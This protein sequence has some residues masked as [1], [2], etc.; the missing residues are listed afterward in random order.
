VPSPAGNGRAVAFDPA[1][2]KIFYTLTNSTD[3]YVTD[4]ANAAATRVSVGI[5]FGALSWDAKRKV[6]WGGAYQSGLLGN[7]YQVTPQ[8]AATLQF[9][10]LPSGGNCYGQTPGFI[11]GLAY[12]EGP[13]LLDSD[14]SL[15]ISDDAALMVHHVDLHGNLLKS[16]RVPNDPRSGRQGCNTGIAVDGE[17]LWL[18]LQSGPDQPPHDIVRVAKSDPTKVVTSFAFSDVG[19][20]GPE[21]LALDFL[22]FG[23]RTLWSNEFSFASAL[24]LWEIGPSL[25][26]PLKDL[27]PEAATINS[28]FDHSMANEEGSLQ[29]YKCD[30]VVVTY[31][32]ELGNKDGSGSLPKSDPNYFQIQCRQGYAQDTL[33]T[34]FVVNGHYSGGGYLYYDGHPGID[35]RAAKGTKVYAAASG[36]IHYPANI[37]GIRNPPEDAFKTFHV[38][39]LVP[40]GFP[41]YKIYYLHLSTHPNGD[42]VP[43]AADD[44]PGCPSLVSLPLVDGSHV[45]RGCLIA[46]SGDAGPKGTPP[47]LHFEVQKVVPSLQVTRQARP[48]FECIESDLADHACIPVDPYGWDCAAPSLRGPSCTKWLA[49]DGTYPD[50]Y[51]ELTRSFQVPEAPPV[52]VKNVRLWKH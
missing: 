16:F 31:S 47:H 28:V 6:L 39:E 38:L 10:F 7:I 34:P 45:N 48:R 14:D 41:D 30:S 35:Y 36:T 8:G 29:L 23:L 43:S 32:G 46:L 2:G 17:Y 9:N 21:G 37:V 27:S 5:R 25:S 44:T 12:D 42:H 33:H 1:T 49:S 20:P 18:A 3:I 26:F 40:D 15:W 52:G 19:I 4:A 51:E 11:D 13:T 24:K 50:P 22:T